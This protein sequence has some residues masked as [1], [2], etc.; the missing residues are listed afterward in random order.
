MRI[1]LNWLNEF[2]KLPKSQK[3]LT[4]KLTMAGHMLDKIDKVNGNS[5]VDLELRGN[6]ADCYSIIG[7]AREVSALF[8]VPVKY[9]NITLKI[10][11]TKKL[12]DIDL[13]VKTPLIKRV[14]MAEI[15]N[16][17]IT[18]SPKWLTKRLQEYGMATINNIVDLT[19]YVMIET[20]ESMHAF[21]LDKVGKNL[22]IRLAKNGEKMTTF[23]GKSVTLD[24]ND[25]VWAN[26]DSVLSVAAAIGEK[27]HSVSSDTKNILLEGANYDRANIRRS[28][29]KH[30]LL[31]E[32]GIRHEKELD[33]NIVENGVY[34]FLELVHENKWGS[35]NR[36]SCIVYDYYPKPITSWKLTLNYD[37]LSSL[38]GI[39][40]EK[41][42]VIKILKSLNFEIVKQDKNQVEVLV[43]TY[44]TDVVLEEDLIE[45]VLRISGYQNIP[46]QIL[47]LEIPK[48]VTPSYIYQELNIKN[49][50]VG[51][52][53]DEVISSTCVREDYLEKN[54]SIESTKY[55]PV[56][57]LNRPS[58]DFEFLR[59]SLFPNL[60]EFT[61]KILN[62][63]E[64][65]SCLFEVGK[66][67]FKKQG[68]YVEKRKLGIIYCQKNG[69]FIYFKGYLEALFEKLNIKSFKFEESD[70]G[71]RI[72]IGKELIGN[73]FQFENIYYCEIDLDNILDKTEK[74]KA[75]L[76]AKYPP[77][78]ED[79]TLIVPEKTKI[80][81]IVHLIKTQKQIS[82]VEMKDV[83]KDSYTFRVWYQNPNKTLTDK[84]VEKIR[85]KYLKEIRE[86]FGG[87]IKN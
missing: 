78:I 19:N 15:R 50:M 56:K 42:I 3:D 73:G 84:E 6:R 47:S 58:Q 55:L 9:P 24:S 4:D 62:E 85:N 63:R 23:L 60:Y 69:E 5:V 18:N 1:P 35:V 71:W 41:K 2:V 79:I 26:E 82:D 57:I 20:G 17:K 29:H 46:T 34:R 21:D 14:M 37:Y 7:I 27:F 48:V 67:Y 68:D 72:F 10:K 51:L 77:Q 54:K 33:P 22:E 45:E 38:S 16:V 31:T 28:I 66:I 64:T 25:L 87:I 44:R 52:G 39:E 13:K 83:Y 59:I 49:Q 86:K 36:N 30:N 65:E 61:Q 11:K 40:F 43:P 70:N 81:E 76:W 32:S 53:F 80:G 74:S 75:N 12:D 8:N